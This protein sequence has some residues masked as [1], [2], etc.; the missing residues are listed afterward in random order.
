MMEAV[1][2][3][4]RAAFADVYDRLGPVVFG[5]AR[6]VL[7]DGA[8]AEEVTKDLFVEMWR[9]APR[10]N[11]GQGDARVWAVTTSHRRAVDRVRSEEAHR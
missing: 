5:V 10:F 9:Q 2:R 1:A 6:R 7:G 8:H 3:G 11:H 4:D